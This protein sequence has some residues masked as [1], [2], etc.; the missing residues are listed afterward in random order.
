MD[1][2][3]HLA[4]PTRSKVNLASHLQQSQTELKLNVNKCVYKSSQV[5][6]SWMADYLSLE[7]TGG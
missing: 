2:A 7:A 1:V 3:V 5:S 4:G 6:L